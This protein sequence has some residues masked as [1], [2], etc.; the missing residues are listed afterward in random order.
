MGYAFTARSGS[1]L[2]VEDTGAP[3]PGGADGSKRSGSPVLCLHGIGGGAFFF[4]G[5]R[6][7]LAANH[8][9][10]AID[11]PGS[12]RSTSKPSDF[13][14]ES[15]IADIGDLI[16]SL[17]EPVV[18]VGHSLGTIL[19]LRAWATWP[20]RI[21]ALVF[22][23]GLPKARPNI[24]ERLSQRAEIIAREGVAGW[25]PKVSPGVFSQRSLRERH[26][27]TGLFEQL[28]ELQRGP[29]YVRQIELLLAAD[30]NAVVPT[31]TAPCAAIAG[32]ED[33]YAPPD[34]VRAFVAALPRPCEVEVLEDAAH[35]AFLEAPEAFAAAV[36]RFLDALPPGA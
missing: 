13:T 23:C 24:H 6:K 16:E 10:L 2:H 14:F 35:M 3:A 36:E 22:A 8:R 29:E 5:F 17:G 26:E 34:A 20:Q 21:R 11:L 18:V 7:R 1:I 31:V 28:F 15:W 12:G 19:S 4:A 9:V 25:G 33:S 30:L 27:I 32:R